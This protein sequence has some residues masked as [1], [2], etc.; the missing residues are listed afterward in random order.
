[1]CPDIDHSLNKARILPQRTVRKSSLT[2][3][4]HPIFTPLDG[5]MRVLVH[6]FIL[7]AFTAFCLVRFVD[8]APPNPVSAVAALEPRRPP[9]KAPPGCPTARYLH[10]LAKY[11]LRS[12]YD[13]D[14]KK[15]YGS[16]EGYSQDRFWDKFSIIDTTINYPAEQKGKKLAAPGTWAKSRLE[17]SKKLTAVIPKIRDVLGDIHWDEKELYYGGMEGNDCLT[18]FWKAT[19]IA[20]LKKPYG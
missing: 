14:I 11:S 16:Y 6:R 10:S 5:I 12:F 2:Y 18:G 1:M 3:L 17:F 8:A 20:T 9:P 15:Q 7:L 4:C 13:P 19:Y